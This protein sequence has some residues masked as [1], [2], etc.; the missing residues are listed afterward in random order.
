MIPES[1]AGECASPPEA[2]FG[3]VY[4]EVS[5]C[6]LNSCDAWDTLGLL[7]AGGLAPVSTPGEADWSVLFTCGVTS[8][9]QAR[10]RKAARSLLKRTEGRVVVSGCAARLF[11]EDYE[12][13][14]GRL[15][16]APTIPEV[17][18]R[19]LGGEPDCGCFPP[20][21]PHLSGATRARL[22]IQD[23]CSNGC[24][25]CVVPAA[26]GAS[27]SLPSRLVRERAGLLAAAGFREI[28]LTGADLASWND[29]GTGED[30]AA[31][32]V[33]LSG[34]LGEGCRLRLG[35]LEPRNLTARF[36]EL[37]AGARICR[38][39]HIPVQSGSPS[40]LEA[41]GRGGDPGRAVALAWEHFPGANI[42][43]DLISGFPGESD[44]DFARTL[45]LV[46]S[47]PLGYLHVFPF[48][49]R[50]GTRAAEMGGQVPEEVGLA[51][52]SLLGVR[53]RLIRE[54]YRRSWL[55]RPAR[56]LVEGRLS[57]GARIAMSDNYIPVRVPAGAREG[58]MVDVVFAEENIAWE[59]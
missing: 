5:G 44:D 36:F 46:D 56:A 47:A 41:M 2:P 22:K 59:R 21:S 39:F 34:E 54:R 25:Y 27:R 40:V 11:P 15:L 13:A 20:P 23:G 30:L 18:S 58:E 55:G 43:I 3:R 50:P 57:G 33:A 1:R 49:P 35:S 32:A 52:A 14:G 12:E 38:H 10:S 48:S 26:R 8:R 45:D 29:P 42:G 4:V 31:M 16:L 19:L 17:V 7:A 51:R 9:G 53:G 6:R 37:L 28:V 24:S